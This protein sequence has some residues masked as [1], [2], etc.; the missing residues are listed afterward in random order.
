VHDFNP[1]L[2]ESISVIVASYILNMITLFVFKQY[3]IYTWALKLLY[4]TLGV[5]ATLLI[6][7]DI[8]ILI[9]FTYAPVFLFILNKYG[10]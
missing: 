8:V 10:W 5:A 7:S 9:A 6:S 2:F 1:N 3:A 4:T